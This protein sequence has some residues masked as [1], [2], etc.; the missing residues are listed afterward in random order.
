MRN[1]EHPAYQRAE[2][3]LRKFAGTLQ[4]FEQLLRDDGF[5]YDEAGKWWYREWQKLNA[6]EE[7]LPKEP[8]KEPELRAE[9]QR[10]EAEL[11]SRMDYL[12][13]F[14]YA[15]APDH[16]WLPPHRLY[17]ALWHQCYGEPIRELI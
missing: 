10:V 4:N 5:D 17:M 16:P 7:A 6:L 12:I 8:N 13:K 2:R 1:V 15:H 14:L 3:K 9:E 11:Y